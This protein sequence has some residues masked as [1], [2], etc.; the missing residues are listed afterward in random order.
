MAQRYQEAVTLFE[1]LINAYPE[2][3][4]VERA[5]L[6]LIECDRIK[7][8]ASVQRQVEGYPDAPRFFP[9][10]PE[11]RARSRKEGSAHH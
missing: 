2:S 3:K 8:C 10:M 1:T 4:Y 6:V 9:S 7:E 11:E 5:K